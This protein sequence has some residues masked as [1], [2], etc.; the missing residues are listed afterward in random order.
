MAS[1]IAFSASAQIAKNGLSHALSK[2]VVLNLSGDEFIGAGGR[3]ATTTAAAIDFGGI[4]QGQVMLLINNDVTNNLVVGL[5]TPITQ[6]IATI[7]PGG[8]IV[9]MG[10][11]LTMYIKSSASTVAYS[12]VAA[13]N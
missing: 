2:N 11:A 5:D 1:E 13:E 7:P 12:I 10:F 4:D 8:F 9:L 3:V 6:I